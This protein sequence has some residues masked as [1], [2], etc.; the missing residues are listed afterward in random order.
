MSAIATSAKRF[1]GVCLVLAPMAAGAAVERGGAAIGSDVRNAKAVAT[2]AG[3]VLAGSGG[4]AL[5]YDGA[6][7][8]LIR[9]FTPQGV[10]SPPNFGRSVAIDGGVA[11]VGVT[12]GVYLFDVAT[13]DELAHFTAPSGVNAPNNFGFSVAISG[14]LAVVGAPTVTDAFADT[15]N[16][17]RGSAYVYDIASGQLLRELTGSTSVDTFPTPQGEMTYPFGYSVAADNGLVLVGS[18]NFGVLGGAAYVFDAATGSQLQELTQDASAE[19]SEATFGLSVAIDDG[20]ALVGAPLENYSSGAV[21]PG[22]GYLAGVAYLFD[23]VTGSLGHKLHA[24]S[25]IDG[26]AFGS[27]VDIEDGVA[28]VGAPNDAWE[29]FLDG[30]DYVDSAYLFDV[31]SG[32]PLATL[33]EEASQLGSDFGSQVALGDGLAV[34]SRNVFSAATPMLTFRLVPEPATAALALAIVALTPACRSRGA[35]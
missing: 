13:G 20:V 4:Q 8:S 16:A 21:A 27:S 22:T 9:D 3:L 34:V 17:M 25:P 11:A 24:P 1:L 23:A 35:R 5:L 7:G 30:Y 28:L 29:E 33:T 6:D 19:G 32:A 2:D 10:V 26:N 15:T 18:P 31:E 12:G 14:G